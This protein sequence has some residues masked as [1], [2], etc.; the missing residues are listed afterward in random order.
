M[1]TPRARVLLLREAVALLATLSTATLARATTWIVPINAS[2]IQ[3]A[4]SVAAAGDTIEVLP[5]TYSGPGNKDLDFGGKS[6]VLRSRDGAAATILDCQGSGRALVFQNGEGSA[7]VVSGFTMT[8]G[9]VAQGGA[10][11]CLGASPT[12]I[13]CILTANRADESGGGISSRIGAHPTVLRCRIE[14]NSAFFSGGGISCIDASASIGDCD[15]IGNEAGLLG[16]GIY[17]RN[18]SPSIDDSRFISNRSNGAGGGLVIYHLSAP[19]VSAC[20]V[21]G[22]RSVG[23]AGAVFCDDAAAP[24]FVD[25]VV[26]GNLTEGSGGGMLC[27]GRSTAALRSSTVSGNRALQKG[28]GLYAENVSGF[29]LERTILWGNCA[30]TD[31]EAHLVDAASHA[32]FTCSDFDSSGVGGLGGVSYGADNVFSDPL[33]CA[34]LDCAIAPD[35]G[36]GYGLNA[37]SPC[38]SQASPCATRIGAMEQA[39]GLAGVLFPPSEGGLS[40]WPHPF[41]D[42]LRIQYAFP[43]SSAERLRFSVHD[44]SGRLLRSFELSSPAGTFE[45]DGNDAAGRPAPSGAYFIRITSASVRSS[46]RVTKVR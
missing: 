6:L 12:L 11:S 3:S 35:P 27:V 46:A 18:A 34:P 20:I 22:N 17:C 40:R 15:L 39:C 10:V 23:S 24:T 28:G 4:I 31:D 32:A 25:C 1:L 16:G 7:A 44:L 2:T 8:N 21:A 29:T 33:F 30:A 14:G 42:R 38:R 19:I 41:R 26:T 37:G 43:G 9:R 36:G 45:W 5:G 13:D